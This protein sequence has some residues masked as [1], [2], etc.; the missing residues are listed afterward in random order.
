M[1]ELNLHLFAADD[2]K[3]HRYSSQRVYFLFF[4]STQKRNFFRL[5]QKV[6]KNLKV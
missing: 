1:K 5:S 6:K 4:I 3:P 2:T